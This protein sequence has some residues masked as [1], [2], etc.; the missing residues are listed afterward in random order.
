M[1]Q[2]P[3]LFAGAAIE[4][5]QSRASLAERLRPNSLDDVVGQDRAIGAGSPLRALIDARTFRAI[6]LFG[7]PGTGKTTIARLIARELD[8][9]FETV[10]ATSGGVKDIRDVVEGAQ[11][12][13]GEFGRDTLLF[14]DE[15]HRFS[16]T[17]QDVLLPAIEDGT[18]GFVGATTEDPYFSLNAALQSR[19]QLVRLE[20][21]DAV[22]SNMLLSRAA[23]TLGVEIDDDAREL[24]VRRAMGD[25]RRLL[26]LAETSVAIAKQHG[27]SNRVGGDAVGVALT[28]SG[29]SIGIADHFDLASALIKSMRDSQPTEALSYAVRALDGGED[30]R[31]VARRLVIFASEDIGPAD[32]QALVITAAALEVVSRVGM[33]E[34]AYTIGQAVLY[35]VSAPKSR[36]VADQ[37]AT[38]RQALL[39]EGRFDVPSARTNRPQT[40]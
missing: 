18:I 30:P 8:A 21:I 9:H 24:L 27:V 4:R 11:R 15:V 38:T 13:S 22:S 6:V 14:V 28:S 39:D 19:V 40:Q 1:S 26:L 2:G 37:L 16:R 7:P 3:D 5:Q 25:G 32:P 36:L 23:Q 33:P 12:R 20:P 34:A 31:F 29:Q 17:Q 10:S 35:C